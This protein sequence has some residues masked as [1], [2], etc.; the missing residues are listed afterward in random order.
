MFII[1]EFGEKLW[2]NKKNSHS[3][4]NKH[5]FEKVEKLNGV[6]HEL[7]CSKFVVRKGKAYHYDDSKLIFI[8][9]SD[10]PLLFVI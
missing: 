10:I 4:Q 1:L 2:I 6:K 3:D 9:I 8:C 7:I 5:P